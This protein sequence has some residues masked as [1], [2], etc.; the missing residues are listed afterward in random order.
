MDG[1][2]PLVAVAGM[3]FVPAV[4]QPFRPVRLPAPDVLVPGSRDV[5]IGTEVVL[6]LLTPH[7]IQN[8]VHVERDADI[9]VVR[10]QFKCLVAGNVKSPRIELDQLYVDTIS[11]RNYSRVVG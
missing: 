1:M 8:F 10:K 4:D 2:L 7:W 3:D 9:D 6:K 5:W 11:I